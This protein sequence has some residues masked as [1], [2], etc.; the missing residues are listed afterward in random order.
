MKTAKKDSIECYP[1]SYASSLACL[2]PR[3]ARYT[4]ERTTPKK[5]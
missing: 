1:F 2:R 5:I 4:F 3:K